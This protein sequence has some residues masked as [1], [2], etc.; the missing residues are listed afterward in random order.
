MSLLENP[1]AEIDE[2]A[3]FNS[4][5][6]PE[7]PAKRADAINRLKRL[8]RGG[9]PKVRRAAARALGQSSDLDLVPTLIFALTDPDKPASREA[10]NALRFVSRKFNGFGLSDDPTPKELKQAVDQWKAWYLRVNP[11]YVFLDDL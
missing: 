7:D 8:V 9:P 4:L 6:L 1:E 11:S 5:K 2:R 10:R 3:I